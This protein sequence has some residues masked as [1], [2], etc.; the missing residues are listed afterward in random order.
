MSRRLFLEI[1][2]GVMDYDDYFEAK[3]DACSKVGF[4]SYQKCSTAIQQL[5]TRE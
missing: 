1:L 5:H 3:L 2:D 4:S